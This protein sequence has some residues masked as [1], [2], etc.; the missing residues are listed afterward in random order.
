MATTIVD[1]IMVGQQGN[2]NSKSNYGS[3]NKA[4]TIAN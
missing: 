4:T 3:G 2:D 1:Q